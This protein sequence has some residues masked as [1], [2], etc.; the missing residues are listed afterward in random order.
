MRWHAGVLNT[1]IVTFTPNPDGQTAVYTDKGPTGSYLVTFRKEP[2]SQSAAESASII[3]QSTEM[4][5]AKPVIAKPGFVYNPYDP[6]AKD[7]VDV[8][9]KTSGSKIKDPV[10]GRL[11]IIP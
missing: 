6:T 7:E 3:A 1:A 4:A 5:T 9:G 8:R 2:N 10:S 11:F